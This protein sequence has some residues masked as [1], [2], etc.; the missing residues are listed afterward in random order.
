MQDP[1][2][3]LTKVLDFKKAVIADQIVLFQEF[4]EPHEFETKFRALVTDYVQKGIV[5]ERKTEEQTEAGGKGGAEAERDVTPSDAG[6]RLFGADAIGFVSDL[7]SRVNPTES[8]SAGDLARFRLLGL[9]IT[10]SGNDSGTLGVHD[11][12]LIFRYRG[13]FKLT[14]AEISALVV[15]GAANVAHQNAPLWG[16]VF[17]AEGKPGDEIVW[18]SVMRDNSLKASLINCLAKAR[19]PLA[20]EDIPFGRDRIIKIWLESDSDDVKKAALTYLEECGTSA[21][22][23][24]LEP[25]M[26]SADTTISEH[27]VLVAIILS[28]G[29]DIDQALDLLERHQISNIPSRVVKI[30]FS[31]PSQLRSDRL[32]SLADHRSSDVRTMAIRT[33]V[34]R[35]NLADEIASVLLEDQ[36]PEVRFLAL[37]TLQKKK[38]T[39]T[40]EE[41]RRTLVREKNKGFGLLMGPTREG[42]E[43]YKKFLRQ[44]YFA[45]SKDALEG[46]VDRSEVYEYDAAYAL[47]EK[48]YREKFDVIARNLDDGFV[49]EFG[50]R[51]QN[52]INRVGQAEELVA[53]I[54][55]LSDHIREGVCEEVLGII[56]RRGDALALDLVRRTLDRDEPDFVAGIVVYL[57]RH[58]SWE[59][60]TRIAAI[61]ERRNYARTGL[62]HDTSSDYVAAANAI[63]RLSKSRIADLFSQTFSASLLAH[64]VAGMT[65]KQFAELSDLTILSFMSHEGDAVRKAASLKSVLGLTK[66]RCRKLLATYTEGDQYRYYNVIHWLDVAVNTPTSFGR[67]LADREAL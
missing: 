56:C 62:F 14:G 41:A 4:K 66:A 19:N 51:L 42:E 45:M 58:G 60:V 44:H 55:G 35:D 23:S 67:P 53:Q 29:N 33:L 18:Q 21:D 63:L 65:N 48:F 13:T 7:V 9:A 32:H 34:S 11:A 8:V 25:Y 6:N 24:L 47:Y 40:P 17:E 39:F 57:E 43:F 3:E 20:S 54:E 50:R 26:A 61:V 15:T 46:I 12:N 2:K 52:L 38:R 59:D 31:H 16:W 10:R 5:T 36:S 37:Q 22:L 27:A 28:C 49:A 30:L 1:G 64:L